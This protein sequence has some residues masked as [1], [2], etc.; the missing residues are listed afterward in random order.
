MHNGKKVTAFLP[1]TGRLDRVLRL[2]ARVVLRP[3]PSNRKVRFDLLIAYEGIVPVVV[4]S[5]IP[6][7]LTREAVKNRSIPELSAHSVVRSSAVYRDEAGRE[8]S[9]R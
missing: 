3:A 5:R 8:L 6:N 2:G 7:L 4:D 9:R 1:N